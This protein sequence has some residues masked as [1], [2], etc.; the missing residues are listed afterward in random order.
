MADDPHSKNSDE[1]A[2]PD[3]LDED[4]G[5]DWESAFQAEEFI[6]S[7]ETTDEGFLPGNGTNDID[8]S[9]LVEARPS[10]QPVKSDP[11]E[12]GGETEDTPPSPSQPTAQ[13]PSF[14]NT[15][16]VFLSGLALSLTTWYRKR[17]VFQKVLIPSLPFAALIIVAGFL[18]FNNSVEKLAQQTEDSLHPV[19]VPVEKPAEKME[20]QAVL[21]PPPPPPQKQPATS[22]KTFRKKW[23][24]PA[25]LIAAGE[26]NN[27][28]LLVSIDL[29][30]VLQLGPDKELPEERLSFIR[31]TIFQFYQN[32]PAYELKQFALARGEMIRQLNNWIKKAWPDSPVS[33]IMFNK[34]QVIS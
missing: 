4:L 29:T 11:P 10:M 23:S 24:L 31:D 13:T 34:Y 27:P 5:D 25:F 9:T 12:I 22:E 28:T 21:T 14:I 7:E 30:L 15:A 32:R 6:F 26:S 2:I 19:T 16:L 18:F 17:S 1:F 3:N 8:L 20:Q 33:T